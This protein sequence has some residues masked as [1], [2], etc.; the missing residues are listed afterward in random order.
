MA[1]MIPEDIEQFITPGEG[2]G[3]VFHGSGKFGILTDRDKGSGQ[4]ACTLTCKGRLFLR[5]R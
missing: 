2:R 5:H 3:V 1:T 4:P